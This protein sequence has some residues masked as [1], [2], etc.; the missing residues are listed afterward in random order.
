MKKSEKSNFLSDKI[1]NLV[2]VIRDG[3]WLPKGHDGEFMYSGCIFGV[4]LPIDVK[5]GGFVRILDKASGELGFFENELGED[6]SFHKKENNFW[7]DFKIKIRKDDSLMQYGLKYDLSD[8][9]D[10]L[11]Y[12]VLKVSPY[13][14]PSWAERFDRAEY[15]FALVDENEQREAKVKKATLEQDAYEHLGLIRHSED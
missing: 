11:R 14:A 13:V 7:R 4:D 5:K 6:L 12:R 9:M 15:R 10:N 2:P 1:V 3:V 8:P